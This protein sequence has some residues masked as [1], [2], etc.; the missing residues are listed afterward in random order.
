MLMSTTAAC[1]MTTA[2]EHQPEEQPK[3]YPD[4][5]APQEFSH[6]SLLPFPIVNSIEQNL[7]RG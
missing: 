4:A 7:I 6:L 2:T 3:E 5:I 1:S